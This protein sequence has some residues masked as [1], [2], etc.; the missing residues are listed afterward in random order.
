MQ[1]AT[2]CAL[3]TFL[4][5]MQVPAA[6]HKPLR[7]S[8]TDYEDRVRGA[9]VGQIIGTLMGFQFEGKV[10]S[11]PRVFVD[12]YP[13]Q[14]E[15]AQ[16]DDD[17]YYELV[18]LRAFEKYGINM[19]LDQ[20]GQQWIESDAGSWGSSEQTRLALA[21]GI[22]GRDAG[23]PRYNRLWWTIGPQFSADIYGMVAPGDPNLAGR[24]ARQYG[25]INGY[26]E[27]TDGAVFVA[28]MVSLAFRETSPRQIVREA[29]KLIHSSSPYRQCLDMVISMAEQ[30]KTADQV[31]QAVED[32]WHI[33]YPPINNGVANGG[34][35]AA[36]VWFGGGDYLETLNLAYRAADF[37]DADCNAANAGAVI[38]AMKGSRALPTHLVEP[39]HDRIAGARMGPVHFRT[40]V[41]ERISDIIRRISALGLKMLAANGSAVSD[42]ELVVPYRA[43]GTQ[44]AEL[45]T[46]G[47]LMRFWNPEWKLERA[48]FGN[49]G[50][51]KCG[52]ATFLD[53]SV[54]ATWPRDEVR[55]LVMRRTMKLGATPGLELEVA[56]DGG[57]SWQL[58]VYVNNDNVLRRVVD[59][60][61]DRGARNWQ[62]VAADVARFREREVEIRI[63]QRTLQ[64][65]HNGG[66]AYWRTIRVR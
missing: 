2:I 43:V 21:K 55:G 23:H 3:V 1:R 39:L 35:V 24:L 37:S 66:N 7:L 13:R 31:F 50:G 42:N 12:R 22:H 59:G 17:Y 20:L 4:G 34:L 36:S 49:S 52:R 41:D 15:A 57:C 6:Q 65:D 14:M 56:A 26:A 30:G 9:W 60:G 29:A 33:E 51:G 46:L 18:A 40:P 28:G 11:S 58:D 47:D 54:L 61:P 45:F 10:A 63:Y 8:L 25:H 32:R 38:G 48:G 53:G 5:T 27:G 19:T 44:P 64:P 16:V 62:T